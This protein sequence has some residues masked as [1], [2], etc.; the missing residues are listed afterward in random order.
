M[1]KIGSGSNK[2]NRSRNKPT[3]YSG[4]AWD[5][6]NVVSPHGS[7][8]YI[9]MEEAKPIFIPSWRELTATEQT[10]APNDESSGSEDTTDEFYTK[11]HNKTNIQL[12]RII[13][14]TL[15]LAEKRRNS[16]AGIDTVS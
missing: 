10:T 4:D 11:I 2:L 6:S 7:V 14:E 1:L 5:I 3:G 9:P 12:K 13:E 8:Q 16:A 15:R